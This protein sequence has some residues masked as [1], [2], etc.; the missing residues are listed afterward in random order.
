M[1][2]DFPEFEKPDRWIR[3]NAQA[4][5]ASRRILRRVKAEAFERNDEL[6]AQHATRLNTRFLHRSDTDRILRRTD[7]GE[8]H[9]VRQIERVVEDFVQ[10]DAEEDQQTEFDFNG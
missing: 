1:K 2:H 4:L 8:E 10:P 9:A 3:T 7:G 6:R 5:A